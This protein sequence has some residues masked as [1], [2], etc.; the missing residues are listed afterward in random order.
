[1]LRLTLAPDWNPQLINL[2]FEVHAIH[3]AA[4]REVFP[5]QKSMVITFT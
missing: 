5:K 4:I 3:V 1:M 2:D